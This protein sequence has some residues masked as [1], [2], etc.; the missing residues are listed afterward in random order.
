[1]AE[2]ARAFVQI[3]PTFKGMSKNI[4]KELAGANFGLAPK[5]QQGL[6]KSI[7]WPANKAAKDAAESVNTAV[8]GAVD[9][10]SKKAPELMKP[11]A[12]AG[13]KFSQ[14]F[15]S[16]VDKAMDGATQVV[17]KKAP[18]VVSPFANFGGK[19]SVAF[20]SSFTRGLES[21][22]SGIGRAFSTKFSAV[23]ASIGNFAKAGVARLKDPS[24]L[25]T[26]QSAGSGI[27]HAFSSP[28]A[29]VTRAAAPVRSAI[30]S[31]GTAALKVAGP[32]VIA[33]K[34]VDLL[35]SGL[36]AGIRRFDTINNYPRVMKNLGISVEE[37]QKS[38]DKMKEALTGLPTSLD[39]AVLGVQ[40]LVSKNGDVGKSTDMFLALNNAI[41]AGGASS[42]IQAS[43]IEQLTQAYAKGKPDIIEWRSLNTAMPAQMK[44]VA[45]A[46]GM[47]VEE[48]GE[49]LTHGKISMDSFM[50]TLMRL[51]TEGTG[52]FASFEEQARAATGG[53][54]TAM[55]NLHTAFAKVWA[56]ILGGIGSDRI[57][58]FFGTIT[59]AVNRFA[60]FIGPVVAQAFN[61][62]DSFFSRVSQNVDFGA[63][64]DMAIERF[65][66]FKNLLQ[67]VFEGVGNALSGIFTAISS[68]D[69]ASI[70]QPIEGTLTGLLEKLQPVFDKVGEFFTWIGQKLSEVDWASTFSS[71]GET[72]SSVGEKLQPVFDIIGQGFDRLSQAASNIDFEAIFEKI[73]PIFDKLAENAGPAIETI[74]SSFS[75]FFQILSEL[76][77]LAEPIITGVIEGLFGGISSFAE[78][79]SFSFFQEG[80]EF[81]KQL[82]ETVLGFIQSLDFLKPV[83]ETIGNII[84]TV[85]ALAIQSAVTGFN[86]LSS[87][88]R[89]VAVIFLSIVEVI[90]GVINVIVG[91]FTG[92]LDKA[93]LGFFQ[94]FDGIR[95]FFHTFVGGIVEKVIGF[96]AN[97]VEKFLNLKTKAGE[98]FSQLKAAALEKISSMISSAMSAVTGF[99]SRFVQA[100]K[101]LVSG[102]VRGIANA[103]HMVYDK[104]TS[105]CK[106]AWESVKKF[107]G[108]HSPSRLFAY[109]GDMLGQGLSEGI[110]DSTP[111]VVKSMA[112]MTDSVLDAAVD[113]IPVGFSVKKPRVDSNESGKDTIR[114]VVVNIDSF[115]NNDTK[116][117][118]NDFFKL[119]NEKLSRGELVYL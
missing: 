27:S 69:W 28:L 64:L 109:A 10:V 102:L 112:K 88:V 116:T 11:L 85:I 78:G 91:L 95:T 99:V 104:I 96:V 80:L 84:G 92:D 6:F 86:I 15:V 3:V 115:I 87:A 105:M 18:K 62:L 20:A 36:D 13:F 106:N 9:N 2:I 113:D 114:S 34:A 107:F 93:R 7:F 70:L 100:G 5:Q 19:S 26:A 45:Q 49:N 22:L 8:G 31:I 103:A 4:Q 61:S 66:T 83:L 90:T 25:S 89:S 110:E 63:I 23:G 37:S 50:D 21:H 94:I 74:V 16:S 82:A 60:N 51:N 98:I 32:L 59:G 55:A 12:P 72:L 43:A 76:W 53:I 54:Q 75:T 97:I 67:P 56:S 48:L 46:M 111:G 44:Q 117:D 24:F 29:G 119:I 73:S 14:S 47:S 101:D 79:G 41:L 108:I 35:F 30:G 39:T 58:A 57:N 17:A 1:M 68:V 81:I 52:E 118:A 42:E 33:K 77:G 65:N 71:I 40:R 38:I